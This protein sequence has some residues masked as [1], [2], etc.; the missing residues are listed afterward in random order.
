MKFWFHSLMVTVFTFLMMGA[1]Y[2]F[3]QLNALEAFDPI[4]QAIG[5]LDLSDIAFS[6]LREGEPE[7]DENVTIVNI[8]FLPRAEIARQ[9]ENIIT[10]R[11]KVIGMDIVFDCDK[12]DPISCPDLDTLGT[13]ALVN[14]F[15]HAEEAGIKVVMAQKLF[16]TST[17]LEKEGDTDI[18]DSIGHSGPEILQNAH[19]G[20]VNLTSDANHQ[21]DIK[22]C[23]ELPPMVM[24][25]GKP[26]LAFS[27]K[28]AMM[29]DPQKTSRFLMR[30][31][32]TEAIN[33]RGNTP[34]LFEAVAPTY[35]GRYQFLDA[36]QAM[37]TSQFTADFIR[38][39][40]VIFGFHGSNM[41]DRTW[42]DKFFT[43]LNLVYAG[44]ARPDMYGVVVH[45]NAVSMILNEDYIDVMPMWQSV[46]LAIL[47]VFLTTALFFKIEEK[48][49]IWYDLLSLF[50]QLGLFILL[51]LAMIL[52]F[53]YYSMKLEF[54]IPLAAV[55]LVGT[56]FE[57]YKGGVLASIEYFRAKLGKSETEGSA[58]SS[59]E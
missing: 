54:T 10:F 47:L 32:E 57:L 50:I 30:G 35:S 1:L 51:S 53:S 39:K 59:A 11:P 49:P 45:A 20:F 4:G 29:Y 28:M 55:A 52:T 41:Y 48:L 38:D 33:F 27:V 16:Q 26:E 56:C 6:H 23:R 25:N 24:V 19:E 46:I 8:G 31:N 15:R 3:L 14:A 42:E 37:D 17:L 36:D 40:V 34:D 12:P 13:E 5:E 9:L 18:Y 2:Q 22:F 44:R 21:E 43:P 7:P 58:E